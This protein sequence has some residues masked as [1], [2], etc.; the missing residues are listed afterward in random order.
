M[1]IR[2][3]IYM[4]ISPSKKVYVGK[5]IC[6]NNRFKQ[7]RSKRKNTKGPYLYNALR[8]YGWDN[9]IKVILE[10]FDDDVDDAFMSEREIYWIKYHESFGP[11]GYNCTKGGEGTLGR[12]MSAEACAKISAAS[13]KRVRIRHTSEA[14]M[15]M[16]K[17]VRKYYD[18]QTEAQKAQMKERN[19]RNNKKRMKPVIA[20]EKKT[21]I[22]REFE[23]CHDAARTLT[24]ETG[25]K[26]NR[27]HI[28]NCAN[29]RKSYNS[30]HGWTFEFVRDR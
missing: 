3:C 22:T 7:Y 4:L 28:G 15:N 23:S 19:V 21:G 29:K 18:N 25:K 13:K 30:H 27:G 12:I 24:C 26:F 17:G 14:R 20:F 11:K 16:S 9:F 2:K 1:D 10:V 5:T 6:L 8:K